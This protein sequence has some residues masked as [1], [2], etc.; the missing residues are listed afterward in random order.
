MTFPFFTMSNDSD[1]DD[2]SD[3]FPLVLPGSIGPFRRIHIDLDPPPTSRASLRTR[4]QA[5]SQRSYAV[6]GQGSADMP[7][8]IQESDDEVEVVS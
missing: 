3:D 5:S 2:E 1:E 7:L 4:T 6:S 8:E